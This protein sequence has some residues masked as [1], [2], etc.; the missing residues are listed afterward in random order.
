MSLP[1][2][3]RPLAAVLGVEVIG[4]D[5]SGPQADRQIDALHELFLQHHVLCIR[6]QKLD[7]EKQLA[8]ARRFGEPEVHP[9]VEGTD[10]HP[11]V[12]RVLK[13]AGESASFGVG[14]HTD[15][16]FFAKPSLGSVL[17]GKTIPPVGGDT[18]YSNMEAAWEGLSPRMQEHLLG[19]QAV[20]SATRAYDP[21]NT[22]EDKYRG[23]AAISY[24]WSDSIRD[25]V[26]HP[27]VRTH[28]ET[29]KRSIYVNPM[30]TLRIE[31]LHA[32][33]SDSLLRFLYEHCVRPEFSCRLRWEP[34]TVAVW[35]NRSVWHYAMDDYQDYERLMF[36]VTV[37]GDVPA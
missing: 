35:D 12:V 26:L 29:G 32:S 34:D 37:A 11:E 23:E 13:P 15:N 9:I 19:M 2:E 30:F 7:G 4:A 21:S 25:E 6:N 8:F 5:L 17:Y 18:L 24:R 10:E 16:S 14:W 1:F 3:V 20:H 28:P 27:V 22:G 33:E 31:E 36:R